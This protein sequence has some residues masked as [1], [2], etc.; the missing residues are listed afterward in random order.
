MT[1]DVPG[2]LYIQSGQANIFLGPQSATAYKAALNSQ[3]RVVNLGPKKVWVTITAKK[4][5][6]LI[7]VLQVALDGAIA[8]G[9]YQ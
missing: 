9:E 1:D 6:G 5:N 3:I 7:S 8:H 4:G 2:N